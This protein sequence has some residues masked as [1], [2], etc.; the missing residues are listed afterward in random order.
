MVVDGVLAANW[1][2]AVWA[3]VGSSSWIGGDGH[4]DEVDEFKDLDA[5]RADM[6]KRLEVASFCAI[7]NDSRLNG[8]FRGLLLLSTEVSTLVIW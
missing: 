7:S 3:C 5:T 1:A 2:E 6:L 4:E 8:E